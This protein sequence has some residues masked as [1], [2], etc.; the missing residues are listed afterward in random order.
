MRIGFDP[1]LECSSRG[2]KRFSAF[3]ARLRAYSGRSIEEIYQASK[4]FADGSTGLDWRAAKGRYPVNMEQCKI[5]YGQ[6]WLI[7]FIENP[8]LTNVIMQFNGFSDVFGKPGSVCQA[9]EIYKIRIG[10]YA[11]Q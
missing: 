3:Y 11:L 7:Y 5:L 9:V 1:F 6:L 2:D 4:V 10:R 8:E